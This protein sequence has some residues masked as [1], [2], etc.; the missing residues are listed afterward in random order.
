M[1][2]EP[3]PAA[4]LTRILGLGFGVALA[5]GNTIGVGI[6]RLPGPV[7]AALGDSTLIA[8]VWILGGVYA[9]L[10][11][12]SVAELA[13]ML[14]VAG[15]FYVYARRAF[16][17]RFGFVMGWN[18]WLANCVAAAYVAVTAAE[19]LLALCPAVQSFVHPVSVLMSSWVPSFARRGVSLDLQ[20]IAL[21]LVA[22]LTALHW[23]GIRLGSSVQNIISMLVGTL[24]VLLAVCCF[25]VPVSHPVLTVAPVIHSVSGAPWWS[26]GMVVALIPALRSVVVTYDGWY[27]AIYMAEETVD[28]A[29]N[30]PKAMIGCALLVTT[31]YVFI[32]LGFLH[33][34]SL[35]VLAAS[36]LPAAD[37]ARA[38]FPRGADL[39]VTAVSLMTVLSLVNAILLGAPRVL[40]AVGRDGLLPS[41]ATHVSESGTPRVALGLTALMVGLLILSGTLE[42]LIAVAAVLYV[43]NY[44]SAYAAVVR[45]RRTE[46]LL[47]RPFKAW[48]YPWTTATVL[49]GSATFLVATVSE[50]VHSGLFACVLLAL[51]APAY[52]WAHH[53]RGLMSRVK[54][55]D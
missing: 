15:G 18:D 49:L 16:G 38:I 29:R 4:A 32:N 24:L 43:L 10:G 45:L 48:G 27:G 1:R 7:A 12:I 44:L 5:F 39:F 23:V 33:A 54:D 37:V 50:D 53:R 42:Q 40:Y 28:A 3:K 26:L 55:A 52:A 34:L 51:A 31:L 36:T 2:A 46:P 17:E 35:P 8:L 13:A 47:L 11:A 14:P 9:L 21:C 22:A 25:V 30:I 41:G 6:L 19:F 20:L